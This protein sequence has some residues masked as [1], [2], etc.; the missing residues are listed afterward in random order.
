MN[1]LIL[2]DIDR[3]LIETGGVGSDVFRSAFEQITGT[4]VEK[5]APVSGRTEPEIFLETLEMYGLDDP[6][7][8]FQRFVVAQAEGYTAR[9]DEMR[10][11][12]RVLP[13]A[14]EALTAFDGMPGVVQSVLTGNP[15]VAAQIKLRTFGLE[16]HI[17]FDVGAYGDDDR[18]RANLVGVAQRR[19]RER[20]GRVFDRT[21]TVLIGDTPADVRAG[22]D[23]GAKVVAVASGKSDVEEL[24]LAHP[25]VVLPDLTDPDALLAAIS[26]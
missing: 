16:R 23:G 7:D 3:T 13:G 12:G 1:R 25:D 19:A 22:R 15:R 26:V 21:T 8:Y 6:G 18:V 9:A 24:T 14:A 11:R 20:L 4:E 2:W 17:D 10:A 5:I